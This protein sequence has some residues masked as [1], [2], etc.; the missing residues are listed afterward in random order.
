MP[1]AMTAFTMKHETCT[2]G[3][4]FFNHDTFLNWKA[5]RV[6]GIP[7]HLTIYSF[8]HRSS[9]HTL[10]TSYDLHNCWSKPYKACSEAEGKTNKLIEFQ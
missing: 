8:L 10:L 5:F 7:Y 1:H 9:Y 4:R 6:V 3:V 2:K